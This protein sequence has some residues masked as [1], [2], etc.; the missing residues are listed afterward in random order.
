ML[1]AVKS[2]QC[3]GSEFSGLGIPRVCRECASGFDKK[4]EGLAKQVMTGM[5]LLERLV[6]VVV[7]V[8][9]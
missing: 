8:A 3:Q 7:G 6:S 4:S 2:G 5:T 9:I 1:S